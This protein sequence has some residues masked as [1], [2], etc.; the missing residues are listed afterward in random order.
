MNCFNNLTKTKFLR[1]ISD[2]IKAAHKSITIAN[3][4]NEKPS[5]LPARFT[6]RKK[7][8]NYYMKLYNFRG[9]FDDIDISVDDEL[10]YYLQQGS[11]VWIAS[12]YKA[13]VDKAILETAYTTGEV[14]LHSCKHVLQNKALYAAMFDLRFNI[15][16]LTTN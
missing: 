6:D 11:I 9:A 4:P 2:E 1:N 15:D 8:Y 16:P 12:K 5:F 14:C 13:I 10:I 3:M 7:L